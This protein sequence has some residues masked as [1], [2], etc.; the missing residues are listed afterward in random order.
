MSP[1]HRDGHFYIWKCPVCLLD[2]LWSEESDI[3]PSIVPTTQITKNRTIRA[4][5]L[6]ER[7]VDEFEARAF[8]VPI[9]TSAFW[10][11]LPFLFIIDLCLYYGKNSLS[12]TVPIPVYLHNSIKVNLVWKGDYFGAIGLNFRRLDANS[13]F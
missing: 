13:G 6:G 4:P 11:C 1:D 12:M 8:K 2:M 3:F 7:R 9:I 5:H 10:L